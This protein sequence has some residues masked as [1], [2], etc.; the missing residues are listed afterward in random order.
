MYA[1]YF[2]TVFGLQTDSVIN[3]NV[4]N[5]FIFVNHSRKHKKK[6]EESKTKEIGW[7]K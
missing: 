7:S 2:G 3:P 1:E 6:H 5:I 4:E